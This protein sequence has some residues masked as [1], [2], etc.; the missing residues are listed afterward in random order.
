[1]KISSTQ[2]M[3]VKR[4]DFLDIHIEKSFATQISSVTLVFQHFFTSGLKHY[5]RTTSMRFFMPFTMC[6][7][8][9]LDNDNNVFSDRLVAIFCKT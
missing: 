6:S 5:A 4:I 7:P 3:P 9:F 8:E 2:A 1:V